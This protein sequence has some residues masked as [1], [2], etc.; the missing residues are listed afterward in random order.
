LDKFTNVFPT[1]FFV[2]R[3]GL[4][5]RIHT[6]VEGKAAGGRFEI[7]KNE[8]EQLVKELLAQEV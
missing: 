7:V 5:R 8:M 3:D 4:V 6:G 1:T 2:G